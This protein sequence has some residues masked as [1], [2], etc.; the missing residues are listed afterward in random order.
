MLL[1][2]AKDTISEMGPGSGNLYGFAV[3]F[4]FA[5]AVRELDLP[6]IGRNGIEESFSLGDT[7]RYDSMAA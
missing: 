2:I 5:K 1:D 6:G 7:V 4:Q 3:H